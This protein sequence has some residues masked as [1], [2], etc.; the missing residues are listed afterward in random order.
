MF[1]DETL[2][3]AGA[4]SLWRKTQ[5]FEYDSRPRLVK[6]VSTVCKA[7]EQ[8]SS[9]WRTETGCQTLPFE[10]AESGVQA[11]HRSDC[12]TQTDP[13][14]H[15]ADSLPLVNKD[16]SDLPGLQEFLQRVE[17]TVVRELAKNARS[18]AFDGFQVNW[19]ERDQTVRRRCVLMLVAC[20]AASSHSVS[21]VHRLQYREAQERG[22][23]VTCLSWNC[24]GSVIA[25]S[26]GRQ[27]I[28]AHNLGFEGLD[29]NMV[30]DGDWSTEKAFVCT[31]NLQRRGLDPGRPDVVID[32]SA[33]VMSLAFHPTRPSLIAGGLYSGEVVVW[34][35]S[36]SQDPLLAQTGMSE[37]THRDPVYQVRWLPVG[38]RAEQVVLSAGTGGR[39]L[40]WNLEEDGRL[41]LSDG[42][43]L[44]CQQVPHSGT[45]SKARSSG[46][47]G[48]TSL[49]LSPWDPDVFLVGS[50][51]GLVLKCS[52]SAPTPAAMETTAT[53]EGEGV[54]LRAPARFSFTPRCGPVHTLH[55]SPFH[56]AAVCASQSCVFLG[57]RNLFLSGGTDGL[58]H[59]HSLLQPDPLLSLRVCDAYIFSLRWS[60][61]RPLL[62]AA[63]TA[64]GTVLIFDLGRRSLRQVATIDQTTGG[65]PAYCL[66][67]N[68]QQTDLLATGN[69]DGSVNIWHLSTELTEQGSREVAQLEQLANELAE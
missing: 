33:A 10:T 13:G 11:R 40:L 31:W 7:H 58:A 59:L 37:D 67:F 57:Y 5:Q 25:C 69:A 50:E 8:S 17:D 47:V 21:C 60:P 3:A 39:V 65:R 22:L 49:T 45:L 34:D 51:G 66:E 20:A 26:F 18:H 12:G 56:S 53:S 23:H 27:I 14:V 44:L 38:R 6:P 9:S 28:S 43:A 30:D 32:A 19:E 48:V 1:T 29:L 52:F 24:T 36:R 35:S 54:T 46:C 41:K 64:L 16:V 15:P 62:F 63:A 61:T 2:E 55:C 68:P 4:E 42:Y